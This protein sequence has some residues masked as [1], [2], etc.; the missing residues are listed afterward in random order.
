MPNIFFSNM[1]ILVTGAA[2]LLGS[3]IVRELIANGHHPVCLIRK[4]TDTNTLEGL[5]LTYAY[6][7]IENRDDVAAAISGC[8]AV[9]H[10]AAIFAH[11]QNDQKAFEK[12]NVQG[13]V[14]LAEVAIQEGINKFIYISTANTI[15]T[16]SKSNP[17]TEEDPFNSSK[18][19][20]HYLNT[21]LKAEEYLQNQV[22]NNTLNAVIINPSFM[23]GP[24]DSKPSSGR[25]IVYGV[26]SP[27]LFV[28]PGGKNF[29]HVRD[30]AQVAVKALSIGKAGDKYLVTGENYSYSEFF[31]LLKAETAQNK[32]MIKL[33]KKLFYGAAHLVESIK[34][35]KAEFNVSNAKVLGRDNY[36]KGSKAQKT[37]GYQPTP[38]KL[39]IQ[40]ALVWFRKK[41]TIT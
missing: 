25:M 11:P 21:K 26:K 38:I 9:V 18:L 34:G 3:N 1:R 5:D 10:A 40:E 16:G 30:V 7:S 35:K 36:Y 23:I 28:P 6:G 27:V 14:N 2:G 19:E 17:G 32:L 41:G 20:S 31:E 39:A 4:T 22:K 33:P 29:V 13:T 37:F 12:I 24:Y 15:G 8:A